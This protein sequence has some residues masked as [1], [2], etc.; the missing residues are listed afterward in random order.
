VD[1]NEAVLTLDP[2]KVSQPNECQVGAAIFDQLFEYQPGS[3]E[4][5]PAL[6]QSWSLSPNHLVY[7]FHIR[8]HVYFSNG[9]P[10]TAEDVVYSFKRQWLPTASAGP[11]LIGHGGAWKSVNATGPLTVQLHLSSPRLATIGN[12]GLVETSIVPKK[13][14]E[15][16]GEKEFALHPVGSGPFMV[17]SVSTGYTTVTLVRNPHYWRAGEPYLDG[18]VFNSVAETNAR[19]LAVRS[20]GADIATAISFSQVASLRHTPGVRMLV[21]P[22]TSTDP[23]FLNN[24][25]PP[26]NEVKVRQALN[27]ATP[28][29]EI[30]KAVFKGMGEPANDPTGHVQDWDPNIPAFP[31]DIAKARQLLK[32]SSVPNGFS[33]TIMIPSGEPDA[34]LVASILQSTW[35][36]LGVHLSIQAVEPTTF[37]TNLGAEKYQVGI[38]PDEEFGL[39][40]W[41]P[42]LSDMVMF[43]YPDSGNHAGGTNFDSQRAVK[44]IREAVSATSEA[45]RK[46]LFG[47]VQRLVSLEEAPMD[48]IAELPS[49]TL[50]SDAVHGFDVLPG[51]FMPYEGVWLQK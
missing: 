14:V 34:A 16:E 38:M 44:L 6:A 29:E 15:R 40:Q 3:Q 48:V 45:E 20:G 10:L 17:K 47:E 23:V 25:S 37:A 2:L 35:A 30:I 1:H 21:R 36:Q 42:D 28:R 46:R 18:L 24:M 39:E 51:N 43:D 33:A 5:Q 12:L 27:Y 50:V 4:P 49:R 9:E 32:E 11:T 31:F 7:T 26:L 19:I 8:P 13:V 41:P 22:Q